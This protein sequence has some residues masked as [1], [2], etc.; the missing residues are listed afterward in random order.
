LSIIVEEGI[1]NCVARHQACARRFH[2]GL[3]RLGLSL[4]VER[5][6]ARL[7]TVTTIKVPNDVDWKLIVEFAMKR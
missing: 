3:Q 7:P 4:F 6:G 1:S 2:D 5:K